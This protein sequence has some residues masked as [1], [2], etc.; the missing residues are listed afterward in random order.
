MP[1]E[2]ADCFKPWFH[3]WVSVWPPL[4]IRVVVA[5]EI[6]D[7]A[8]VWMRFLAGKSVEIGIGKGAGFR[9]QVSERV[10]KIFGDDGL[11]GVNQRGDASVAVAMV[12]EGVGV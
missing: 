7:Q 11:K 12:E 6:I 8:G 5:V 1:R 4:L 10:V 2:M 9:Q 3:E